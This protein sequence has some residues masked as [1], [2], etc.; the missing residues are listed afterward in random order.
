MKDKLHLDD[1]TPSV[2]RLGRSV[3]YLLEA[4]RIKGF[5]QI[6]GRSYPKP[7]IT[8]YYLVTAGE[9]YYAK[10]ILEKRMESLF[11]RQGVASE[12]CLRS[13]YARKVPQDEKDRPDAD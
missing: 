2:E 1:L 4:F 8:V 12:V 13:D 7:L 10:A 5:F 3:A 11:S 6:V 9:I